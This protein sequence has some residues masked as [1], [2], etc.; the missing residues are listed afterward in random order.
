[1][2]KD[3]DDSAAG[4]ALQAA[5]SAELGCT[6]LN[7]LIC[8][9]QSSH[10]SCQ[11]IQ[12][13]S[14]YRFSIRCNIIQ[15]ACTYELNLRNRTS[16]ALTISVRHGAVADFLRHPMSRCGPSRVSGTGRQ[17][18]VRQW[19]RGHTLRSTAGDVAAAASS[20]TLT[21]R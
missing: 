21:R 15:P 20:G 4:P 7:A 8:I 6:A 16:K 3:R 1:M 18:L 10:Y 17:R 11:V 19:G 13:G 14:P 2:L 5:G 9:M 12:L